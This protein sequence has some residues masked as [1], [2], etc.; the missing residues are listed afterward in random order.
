MN[1]QHKYRKNYFEVKPSNNSHK[2]EKLLGVIKNEKNYRKRGI[3][4]KEAFIDLNEWSFFYV[5]QIRW[6][7]G[8]VVKIIM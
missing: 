1:K 8:F 3:V 7:I 2:L 5:L 6:Y 4:R